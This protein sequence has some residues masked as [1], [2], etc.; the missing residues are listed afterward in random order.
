MISKI[1]LKQ[2]ENNKNT[3][4]MSPNT[5]RELA[6]ELM[7]FAEEAEDHQSINLC[8]LHNF[9][10]DGNYINEIMINP[11]FNDELDLPKEM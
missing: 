4:I 9:L 5:A 6:K 11:H 3:I 8:N 2:T 1:E 10:S 7:Y